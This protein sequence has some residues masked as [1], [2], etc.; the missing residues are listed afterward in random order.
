MRRR[1]ATVM[2]IGGCALALPVCGE[3][4]RDV[5]ATTQAR[6]PLARDRGV[7]Q[8][9]LDGRLSRRAGGGLVDYRPLDDDRFHLSAGGRL[10]N[11]LAANR[12]LD[13][14]ELLATPRAG[15]VLRNP[16]R[17][18]PALLMGLTQPT[19]AGVALGVDAGVV[20]GPTMDGA[21]LPRGVRDADGP[22]GAAGVARVTMGMKF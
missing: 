12:A 9:A 1:L 4:P 20:L 19:A 7:G 22:R 16:R 10:F 21:R 15:S 5:A 14:R 6:L 8:P 18:A 17:A 11:R 13:E 2:A 3:E